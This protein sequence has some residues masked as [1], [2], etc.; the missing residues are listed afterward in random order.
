MIAV[1]SMAAL[2]IHLLSNGQY[3]YFRDELY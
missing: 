3:G 2:L 1:F